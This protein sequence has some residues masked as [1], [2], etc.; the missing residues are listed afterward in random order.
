MNRHLVLG[1][2]I[3]ITA[4]M[5]AYALDPSIL[6]KALSVEAQ[7]TANNNTTRTGTIDISKENPFYEATSGKV[8]SQRVLDTSEGL[9]PVELSIIQNASIEG[10]GNITNLATWTNTFKTT[11][12][13]YGVGKGVI[14]T[15]NGEMATWIANDIGRS[16]EKGVITYRGLI[17]FNTVNS[18]ST[19]GGKLA[20]LN[21]MEALF[22]TQ[23]NVSS[24]DRPQVTKMWEWK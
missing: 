15:E 5:Y 2:I 7:E 17:F 24:S 20:F 11:K 3:M 12:V 19:T 18:S 23:V 21:N 6:L 22:I 1:V 14:T 9:P 10:V 4:I 13:V 8:I 16:D